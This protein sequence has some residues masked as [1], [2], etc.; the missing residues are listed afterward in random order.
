MKLKRD[1]KIFREWLAPASGS[2]PLEPYGTAT[3]LVRGVQLFV[4]TKVG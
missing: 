3:L 1:S 4:S 2:Q